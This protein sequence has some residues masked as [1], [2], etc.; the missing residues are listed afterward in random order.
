[1]IEKRRAKRELLGEVPTI[2]PGDRLL[3]WQRKPGGILH[4]IS[5][6]FSRWFKGT[7]SK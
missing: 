7:A 4:T 5:E 1:M 6:K 3:R 2:K